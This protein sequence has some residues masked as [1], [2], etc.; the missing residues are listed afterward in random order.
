MKFL[1]IALCCIMII[2]VFSLNAFALTGS[3]YADLSQSSSTVQ[4]LISYANNYDDFISSDYVVFQS[5]QYSYYIFWGKIDYNGTSVTA[6]DAQCISYIREGSGYDYAYRYSYSDK[7]SLSLTVN[8]TVISNI[9]ELGSTS[10][11]Y[12]EYK[13]NFRVTAFNVFI[14]AFLFVLVIL[15]FRR[16]FKT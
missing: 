8:H 9:D 3:T 10:A 2:A 1:K 11:L 6:S 5:G 7:Q 4:N 15:A 16:T 13:Q 12:S 14:I